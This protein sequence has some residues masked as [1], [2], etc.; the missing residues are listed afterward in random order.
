MKAIG[1]RT[2]YD[3][4]ERPGFQ[5]AHIAVLECGHMRRVGHGNA[6]NELTCDEGCDDGR[7]AQDNTPSK[8]RA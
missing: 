1:Y 5:Y 2:N 8:V 6:P 7:E 3:P 4:S